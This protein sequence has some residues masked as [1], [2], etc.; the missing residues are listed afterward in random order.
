MVARNGTRF[1]RSGLRDSA[2]RDLE[3]RPR[4]SARGRR[5]PMEGA[6]RLALGVV[7]EPPL[8][9]PGDLSETWTW[10]HSPSFRATPLDM[11]AEADLH[12]LQGINQLIGHGWPYTAGRRRVSGLALLR[13][14]RLQ[15]KESVVDRDAGPVPLP[16]ASQLPAAAGAAGQRRRVLPAQ[17]RRLG[18]ASRRATS[19]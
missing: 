18:A 1:P 16:A 19:T 13:G 15:R 12:F 11:K 14:R 8:R 6:A 5:R 2:G 9:A 17:Q 7:G 3:Q 10:L 4:R